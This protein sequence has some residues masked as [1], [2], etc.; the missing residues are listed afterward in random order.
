VFHRKYVGCCWCR[1]SY[2][3]LRRNGGTVF[4]GRKRCFNMGGGQRQLAA[5]S[6]GWQDLKAVLLWG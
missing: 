4:V 6:Q 3:D 5:G 1:F 2:R